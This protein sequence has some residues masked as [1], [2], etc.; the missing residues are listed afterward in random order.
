MGGAGG[1]P[2]TSRPRQLPSRSARAFVL[3]SCP[4]ASRSPPRA[5]PYHRPHCAAELPVCG[6]PAPPPREQGW[7]LP[8]WAGGAGSRRSPFLETLL[9]AGFPEC[10]GA[11]RG[12][13]ALWVLVTG[14]PCAGKQRPG[15]GWPL[16]LLLCT[17][18]VDL[19][20][21]RLRWIPRPLC[22]PQT[23]THWSWPCWELCQG[24]LC[25]RRPEAF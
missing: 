13:A 21:G 7:A 10:D 15:I 5:H 2:C 1:R 9:T 23:G 25:C 16:P 17:C 12:P 3:S 24:T 18:L 4:E 11:G 19:L 6:G 8:G 20:D 14:L 22:G